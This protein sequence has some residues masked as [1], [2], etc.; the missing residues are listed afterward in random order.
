MRQTRDAW[1]WLPGTKGLYSVRSGYRLLRDAGDPSNQ[2][3]D[4]ALWKNIWSIKALPKIVNLLWKVGS[5]TLPM[6]QRLFQL[7]V[8]DDV[9]CPVC[10]NVEESILHIL[11]NCDFAKS[12]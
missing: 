2:V 1:M 7:K 4:V 6:K 11:C 8:V 9:M 3:T 10:G 5:N 12:Y